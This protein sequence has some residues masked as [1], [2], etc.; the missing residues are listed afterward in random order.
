MAKATQRPQRRSAQRN[1]WATARPWVKPQAGT[2][3]T[4]KV[5]GDGSVEITRVVIDHHGV[6]RRS[7]TVV[8]PS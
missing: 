6:I 5:L 3:K 7:K 8:V 1:S 4:R 2:T